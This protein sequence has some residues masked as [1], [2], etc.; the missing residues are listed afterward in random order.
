MST[1]TRKIEVFVSESN[2]ETKNEYYKTLRNWSN[3]SRNYANDIMNLLQS[4][5]FF[6]NINKDVDPTNKKALNEYLETSKR[7]LGY[8][9]FANKYK[10]ILPS[11]YRTCINSYVFSNFGNSIKDVLK[12]DSSIISYKKD[13]P[14]LFMSKSIMN[15]NMDEFG[16]SFNFFSIPFRIN[17]GRD[18]SNN[19]EIVNKVI[20]GE[21][22]MCDS[23]FKFYD[24]KLFLLLVINIPETK[25]EL[26]ENNV[27]GVD[28]GITN[29]AYV[30]VNTNAKFRQAIGNTS[31]F[32][33]TRLAIQKNRR[34][35]QK[36]LKYTNGG[37]GRTKKL[38]KLD[39]LG[40]KERNFAKT[41][42][43]TI[44]KEIINAAITN[45]CAHIN[46]E[47]LKGFSKND[48]NNFIL[49]NWSYFE[50]Q[51]MIKYKAQL[52]GIKVNVVNPRYSSQRCSKC[53]H[54][55]ED[56]RISQ[57]KFICQN[58]QF[59]D[60]ADYNAS[61]NI[62]M[63]HTNEYKKEIEKYSKNKQIKVA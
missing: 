46:I 38:S 56:N 19:R 44:S 59:E 28:L 9:V 33:N 18:K 1:I 21:Y 5:Y 29:P 4:T 49:R 58:C 41:M 61:K 43:H 23:S 42:N 32:L 62:S 36:N 11:S 22:K 39:E 57:S 25:V 15:L 7:N 26:N 6:D 10:E 14:L 8:K 34:N 63:A 24:N 13:F 27:L 16:A 3:N 20:S 55:H 48:K 40:T 52:Y 31:S 50:L 30:S 37:K 47:D 45:K 12:G 60:N 51:T 2:T 17:F 35:L 53:G 54:I